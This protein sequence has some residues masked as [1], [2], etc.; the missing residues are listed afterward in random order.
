MFKETTALKKLLAMK[1]KIRDVRGSTGAGKTIGITM[2]DID[3]AQS[4][5]NEIIDVVSESFPHLDQGVMRDFKNIMIEQG[6]WDDKRWNGTMHFYTFES[7][8]EI[9]FQ[10]F[11]K[12][13]KAHGPRRDVLHLN[14]ANYLPWNVVDQL[15][16]R[17]RKIVWCEYNPSSEFWMHENVLGKRKDV[18]SLKLTY[19]DN[20]G[21]TQA[22]IDEIESHKNNK[23]WWQVY[24]L[25]ELGTTEGKIYSSWQIIDEVPHEARL[26]R[27]GLDF[28]YTNDP[29]AIVAIY[30]YNGGYI[31][32]EI[33]FAKGMSNK[34]IAD[35]LLNQRKALV[36]ADSAEPKSIDEIQS[37][38]LNIQP[39][40]KGKDS[41][42]QGIQAVQDQP[43]SVTKRSLN[44]IRE[45]RN[46]MWAKDRLGSFLSP[47][48]PEHIFSHSMD[49]LVEGTMIKTMKGE[50]PIQDI[51]IG[52]FV[53]T[54]N[55]LKKV[56]DSWLVRQNAEV[57]RVVFSNGKELIGTPNHRIWVS[58]GWKLLR[59]IRYG[60]ILYAWNELE[61]I[62]VRDISY[63]PKRKNIISIMGVG[64]YI[65]K[66]GKIIL[67]KYQKVSMFIIRITS[68]LITELRI[69]RLLIRK[70]MVNYTG[71]NVLQLRKIVIPAA[72]YLGVSAC[73][74]VIDSARIN[75]KVNGVEIKKSTSLR[76]NVLDAKNSS[77]ITNMTP[78]FIAPVFVVFKQD[79]EG[80]R[81]V[82]DITVEDCNEY[83]ANGI[84]VHNSIRYGMMSLVPM[85]QRKEFVEN[86]P[87]FE[88]KK[89]KNPA[90]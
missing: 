21:L 9:H 41:V 8:S 85:I 37:Y 54:R 61:S 84:L 4:S 89:R 75:A 86:M 48:E 27:Y 3:Y 50:K 47:N 38:G 46:Y 29:T 1:K 65:G 24:G 35:T 72:R 49:C 68:E 18:E 7:K 36:I 90:I 70:L 32:D 88:P 42:R 55:G 15:I 52:D 87:R 2:W 69:L 13:G 34:Q 80:K 67:E 30:Y 64:T 26:E 33:L 82:Y 76:E 25:G 66:Y 20:E 31:L 17:T 62:K 58:N 6:Y 74:K 59:D 22:E 19:L 5:K 53:Y 23:N 60:D 11:D 73:G 39:A 57:T 12:L 43:I 56:K 83:Y 51:K 10:S 81:T 45:Y 28:G 79:L 63:I 14:E 40:L 77:S 44:I 71:N 78:L 16:T